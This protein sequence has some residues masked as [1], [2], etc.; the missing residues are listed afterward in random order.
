MLTNNVRLVL[1]VAALLFLFCGASIYATAQTPTATPPVNPSQQDATRPPGTQTNQPVPEQAR[2]ITQDPTAP[3]GVQRTAPQAPP[4]TSV[5]PQ[6]A[7]PVAP[8]TTSPTQALPSTPTDTTSGS[9]SE[10]GVVQE[11]REPNFPNAQPQPVPPLPDLT[12]IGITSDQTITLT[13]NEAIRRALENNN[14]IEIARDDVRIAETSLRSLQGIYEPVFNFTPQIN[15]LIQSQQS[16]LS[17]STAAGTVAQTDFT[18]NSNVTKLFEP[19]GGNYQFFFNNN[20]RTTTSTFNTLNPVFS[21]SLGATF[22]QPLWR[23]RSIDNNR[24]QIRIQ[25]KRLEQSDADFRRQ[26]I[27]VISQVQRAYWDLVFALRDQQNKIA[28]LNLARENLR[29]IEAQISAGAIAPLGRA[30]I[31]TELS[32]RES[33]LL[34]ASQSVSISENNLKQLILRDPLSSDWSAPIMPTDE[35]TFDAAP[36]N[37]NDALTEARANR[38]EL[39]RLRLQHDINDID[40]KYFKNQTRPRIDLQST[41]ATTGLSGTP[42]VATGSLTGGTTTIANTTGQV[43]LIFGDPNTV[44]SAFLL[45]QINQLRAAQGLGAATVPLITPQTSSVPTDLIGGY[46]R[47]LSNLFK[48]NTRNVVVGV[49]LQ[50][51]FHNKTAEANLAGARIQ[52][53]QLDATTRVQEQS[54]EVE[55]RNAAQSVETARRR[56]LAARS[57]RQNAELQLTGEQRLYQV[58]R[59]TTFLLFQRENELANARNLEIRAETDY[60]KALADLQRATSTTLRANNVIVETPTAP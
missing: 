7:T 55:V 1:R 43:P 42:V 29:R 51:P 56:V 59:S 46:G 45:S 50:I 47:T 28:N 49:A 6:S 16:T 17:G 23:D 9:T 11:P 37:L 19:G 30:E 12:R 52:R 54:V 14:N 36:V 60:N 21:G 27:D 3:P 32:N 39:Q 2:P 35:P 48:F 38:P 25:R 53:S 22:T 26:T 8:G 5:T 18:V 44:A 34:I 10:P 40:L 13:L 20:R 4:G 31:Q 24:R 57:A 58:G 33:D 15:N 41:L